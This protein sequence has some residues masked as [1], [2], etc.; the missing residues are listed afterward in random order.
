MN[1][2]FALR[3]HNGSEGAEQEVHALEEIYHGI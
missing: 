2:H 1:I 3:I